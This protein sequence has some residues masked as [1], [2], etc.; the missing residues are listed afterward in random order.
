MYEIGKSCEAYLPTFCRN[1]F[2]ARCLALRKLVL[3]MCANVQRQKNHGR[4]ETSDQHHLKLLDVYDKR[5]NTASETESRG[6][7]R[8]RTQCAEPMC[9]LAQTQIAPSEA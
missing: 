3:R 4:D 1:I 6:I 2:L 9:L 7:P 8:L 5:Q